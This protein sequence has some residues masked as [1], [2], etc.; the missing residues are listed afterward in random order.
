[1]ITPPTPIQTTL[2]TT[3]TQLQHTS[4]IPRLDAE[5]ILA[6]VLGV[7]RSYILARGDRPL[8]TD[9]LHRYKQLIER[10]SNGEP[11]AYLIG[12][13]EFWSLPLAVTPATLI[14]R[15]E[16]EQLVELCLQMNSQQ[17]C[18]N[19]CDLGTGSGA[20]ALAIAHERPHWRVLATDVS[21]AA[22][23]VARTNAA[24]L[25]ITNVTFAQS[26]WFDG[27]PHQKFQIII[28]NPPY[29]ADNDP[30]LQSDGLPYEPRL[31]LVSPSDGLTAL[32]EIATQSRLWLAQ[33]GKIYLEHGYDQQPSLI[34]LL[35]DLGYS[36][37][38]GHNDLNGIPRVVT[39]QQAQT[40]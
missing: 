7:P 3:T 40:K 15:P 33:T 19:V 31:A 37:V 23:N 20:I 2:N 25:A 13:R 6:H 10:R 34:K 9:E 21:E 12:T 8:T 36:E 35:T 17:E 32:R 5:L 29:I 28:S 27:I 4:G 16:T 38:K 14:P 11:I 24:T 30:H 22:L 26:S 1:M 18:M 39:A